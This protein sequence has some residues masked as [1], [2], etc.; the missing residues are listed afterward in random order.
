MVRE[1]ERGWRTRDEAGRERERRERRGRRA[2]AQMCA[3]IV[4]GLTPS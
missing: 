3:V 2:A 4:S 1:D